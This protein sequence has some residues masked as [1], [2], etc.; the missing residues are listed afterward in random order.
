MDQKNG[1]LT[2]LGI[3]FAVVIATVSLIVAVQNNTPSDPDSFAGQ[4]AGLQEFLDGIKPG[5]V[6]LKEVAKVL[7][8]GSTSVP[9]Y[10]N[11][12]GQDVFVEYGSADVITGE[13]ASSTFKAYVFATSSSSTAV[14]AWADFGTLAEGKRALINGVTLATSTTATTTSSTYA[15]QAN[16]GNGSILVP[17]GSTVFGYIQQTFATKC[18]G[19]LCETATSTN[20]GFNPKFK[21]RL[22]T[23][24]TS[25]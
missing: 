9:L 24:G 22:G 21:I 4:R 7:P 19:S 20:R 14:P 15:A 23:Y 3:G 5:D 18:T 10:T 6:N 2:S 17:D 1:F 13:T 11:R 25:F 16:L 8:A 12:T